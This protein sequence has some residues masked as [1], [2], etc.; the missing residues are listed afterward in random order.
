MVYSSFSPCHLNKLLSKF[1]SVTYSNLPW[2]IQCLSFLYFTSLSCIEV[3]SQ[4]LDLPRSLPFSFRNFF[5]VIG[6]GICLG[7]DPLLLPGRT[8]PV[9]ISRFCNSYLLPLKYSLRW[10]ER[11]DDR[12]AMCEGR[13]KP[14]WSMFRRCP[15]LFTLLRTTF[16][17]TCKWIHCAFDRCRTTLAVSC[18]LRK[19]PRKLVINMSL[20]C[21]QELKY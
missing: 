1:T 4:D 19:F 10:W 20:S 8:R 12:G 17:P 14:R 13:P 9:Y 3:F 21:S 18:A 15:G 6:A 7:D 5:H 11:D 16:T 2:Y